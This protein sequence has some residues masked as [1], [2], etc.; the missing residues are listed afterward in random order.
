VVAAEARAAAGRE[1][2]LAAPVVEVVQAAELGLVVVA[3]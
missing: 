2:A 3:V 1:A